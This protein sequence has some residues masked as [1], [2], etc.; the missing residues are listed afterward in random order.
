MLLGRETTCPT[1]RSRTLAFKVPI[2]RISSASCY[3]NYL[4]GISPS[5]VDCWTLTVS[6][7]APATDNTTTVVV[8]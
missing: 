3:H 7:L 8:S 5:P 2:A 6:G 1:R 4:P